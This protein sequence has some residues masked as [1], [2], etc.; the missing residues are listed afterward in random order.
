LIDLISEWTGKLSA[1]LIV[2]L[3]FVIGY[4]VVAR[5]IFNHSTNW[6]NETSAMVFG[7]YIILGGAYTLS[8]GGHVNMDLIYQRFSPRKKALVD[9]I[10]FLF[11]ALFC[12]VLVWKGGDRA[13]YA[14]KNM[15]H[16]GTLWN[17]PI[18]P[19]KLVLPIGAFLLLLQGVA[20]FVRDAVTLVR[21][22]NVS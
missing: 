13:W 4:E 3:S 15:E 18:Y 17:P 22:R 10:T 6:A 11:F 1:F 2:V 21:G 9:I 16:S 7:A 20:K 8:I 12:V 14:L 19:I 5:Y